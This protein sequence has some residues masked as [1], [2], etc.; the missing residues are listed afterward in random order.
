VTESSQLLAAAVSALRDEIVAAVVAELEQRAPAATS[1]EEPWRLWT[2]EEVCE[3]LGRS[4]RTVREWVKRGL[5][6]RER[7]DGGAWA[8]DPED[9]KTFAR[10]RRIGVTSLETLA[11]RLQEADK[12]AGGA[13]WRVGRQRPRLRVEP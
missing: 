13:G 8:F 7:L 2:L 5:L 6:P 3:R 9:V 4:D 10:A 12:A 11:R 1:G